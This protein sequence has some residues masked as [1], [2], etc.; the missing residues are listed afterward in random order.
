MASR[1]VNL[2]VLITAKAQT[3]RNH[4]S[5]PKT[6]EVDQRKTDLAKQRLALANS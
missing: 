6:K 5:R 3:C 2:V 4:K 1:D